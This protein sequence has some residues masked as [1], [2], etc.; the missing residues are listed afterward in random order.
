ML[1]GLISST[2]TSWAVSSGP[3]GAPATSNPV[4]WFN[5]ANTLYADKKY[6]EAILAY[7][8][9]IDLKSP[10]A[11]YAWLNMAKCLRKIE[12]FP[13]AERI[14]DYLRARKARSMTPKEFPPL[15]SAEAKQLAADSFNKGLTA[16]KNHEYEKS[17]PYFA[18]L[19]RFHPTDQTQ[20]FL[21]MSN[22]YLERC[23][24]AKPIFEALSK[25]AKDTG[26]RVESLK[27][28]PT[29]GSPATNS[30]NANSLPPISGS[31]ELSGGYNSNIFA[32]T[33]GFP[34]LGAPAGEA[35]LSFQIP[36]EQ[37]EGHTFW[38]DLLMQEDE[39]VGYANYRTIS[40]S[41]SPKFRW[42]AGNN[43][44]EIGPEGLVQYLG[45]NPYAEKAG[46]NAHVSRTWRSDVVTLGG[47]IDKDFGP[48]NQYAYTQGASGLVSANY[49]HQFTYEDERITAD[50]NLSYW[51]E[52]NL[53]YLSGILL[54]PLS[55]TGPSVGLGFQYSDSSL[56]NVAL[57]FAFY[58]RNYT[59]DEQPD[60]ETRVDHAYETSLRTDY[61]LSPTTSVFVSGLA[62]KNTST[63]GAD[64][65][66][67]ENFI[68]FRALFGVTWKFL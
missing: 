55:Y 63:L 36:Y 37:G 50:A 34:A 61:R 57:H 65:V 31:L 44:L 35:Q 26:V 47:N 67:N 16:Y 62:L 59:P 41:A 28:L 46:F 45:E 20:F 21:G 9:A 33:P 51:Y 10:Y 13:A 52:K 25:Q 22:Y 64:S 48:A 3:A 4:T 54:F 2:T 60:N 58:L 27:M 11:D 29:C 66:G 6:N 42:Y 32:G 24:V 15:L 1:A 8:H 7:R 23:D 18:F 17:L 14:V 53:N 5:Y 43:S 19:G 12:N 68:D 38:I 30:A 49:A 39:V 56:W 40:G